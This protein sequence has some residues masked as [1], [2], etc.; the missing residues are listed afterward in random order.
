[1]SKETIRSVRKRIANG[2]F[3]LR[4]LVAEHLSTIEKRNSDINAVTHLD[5]ESAYERADHIE[6]KIKEGKAG[7]LAGAIIGIK[8]AICEAGKPATCASNMLRNFKSVY[9]A[10]VIDRMYNDDALFLARHNMDEFAMGST[11]EYSVHGTA[12]N[13][14][15]TDYVTGGSS[16]GSAAAVAA[17]FVQASLGSDTGGSI[18]QPAAYCGVV[19]LKPSYGRVSRYGLIAYASSFD[20]IGPLTN[21]VEDAA[22]ILGSIAGHDKNDMTSVAN[23]VADYINAVDNPNKNIRIGIPEEYFGEG[24][25]AEIHQKIMS[26]IC[27]LEVDG[28]TLVPIKLPHS[29]YAISTYYILATAEASSNLARY[30]GVRYGHRAS[31]DQ[32]KEL[33][34]EDTALNKMYKISR[35]EGFGM[36]VKRRIMLGTYVLS[37]GYYDAYY[38]KAQ[39][40]RRL[41]QQDFLQAFEQVDIIVSPTTPTTAFPIGSKLDNPVQMYL[42]DIYTISANLAGIGG[43]NVPI[44]FHSNGLPMGLQFMASAFKEERLIASARLIERLQS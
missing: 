19:G 44:G 24:L 43:I 26:L 30:D 18:R 20:S 3:R 10:T 34:S 8:E 5:Y 16:G 37:S 12:R 32:I 13:P 1:M 17:H 14:H 27:K 7:P 33:E 21:S 25:D 22:L 40:V 29:E 23:P 42:N 36:E 15:N 41:I 38:A 28:A 4:N 2:E 9:N 6:A 35:T 39:K 11:N 31:I